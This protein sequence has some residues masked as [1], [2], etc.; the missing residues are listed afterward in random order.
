[1]LSNS[2]HDE[3]GCYSGGK[4]GDQSGGEW[5]IVDWYEYPWDGGWHC[6]L[7]HPNKL[8]RKMIAQ[9]ATEAAN[10]DLIGYDQ[11]QRYTFWQALEK[12]GY[13]PRQITT[14]CEGDCSAGVLAICKATG[15]LLNDEKLKT[16]T[17][18]G[19]TGTEKNILRNAG[20][21]VRTDSKYLTS[22]D[23]LYA[24][25][26][27]LNELNHTCTCVTDGAKVVTT[28]DTK[29]GEY[30]IKPQ[31][32]KRNMECLDVLRAKIVLKARGY[33][34]ASINDKYGTK[35][36]KATKLFQ[37]AAGLKQTGNMNRD[38]WWTLFGLDV[39]DGYMVVKECKSGD[40]NTSVLLLQ[41]YLKTLGYYDGKLDRSFGDKTTA[42]L[43]AYQKKEKLK[44]TGKW[45]LDVIKHMIG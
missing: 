16:I 10:N 9:L 19:Y 45:T 38:T 26:I 34:K 36:I 33:Y 21:E 28:P 41:E 43:K 2:G 25:D 32:L 12:A 20:F 18:Y 24:G 15:Y 4:A 6:I 29:V 11:S 3:L 27:L 42:A 14:P 37:A 40:V 30:L 7:H 17:I 31:T 35:A 39:K 23:Y 13:Y 5:S 22:D 8:V 1:M 44:V